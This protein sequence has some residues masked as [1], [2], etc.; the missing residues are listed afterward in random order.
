MLSNS[1]G[2]KKPPSESVPICKAS[3]TSKCGVLFLI[4][5]QNAFLYS[6]VALPVFP[7]FGFAGVFAIGFVV[8]FD[9]SS[10]KAS[11]L[12][13]I[14]ISLPKATISFS[15]FS[16]VAVSS[17]DITSPLRFAL[18]KN[19]FAFSQRSALFFLNSSALLI[20]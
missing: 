3:N 9:I 10:S 4:A 5:V 20:N 7:L 19:C 12:S 6:S 2:T 15:M 13:T 16:Y 14:P 11:R 8:G 1:S 17:A 18:S